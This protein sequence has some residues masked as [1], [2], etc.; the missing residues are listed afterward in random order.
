MS[1]HDS[2]SVWRI[3]AAPT[4]IPF[5]FVLALVIA[6]AGFALAWLPSGRGVAFVLAP[7]ALVIVAGA[8]WWAHAASVVLRLQLGVLLVEAPGYRHGIPLHLVSTVEVRTSCAPPRPVPV[9]WVVTGVP[10]SASGRR[11]SLG[12]ESAVE[13]VTAAGEK[14]VLAF[15]E[16]TLAEAF[17][18]QL[19]ARAGE[20]CSL[21]HRHRG[22]HPA[23]S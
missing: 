10:R 20:G 11:I 21:V 13:I 12:G 18:E 19:A 23:S 7:A 9:P 17:A 2:A 4:T 16:P 22:A 6:L 5:G 14:Y 3:G 8:L 1:D 15:N